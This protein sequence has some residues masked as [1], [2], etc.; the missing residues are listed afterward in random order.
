MEVKEFSKVRLSDGTEGVIVDIWDDDG[1]EFEPTHHEDL[2]DD[3]PVT[4]SVPKS[5]IAEVLS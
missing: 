2:Q 1:Y 3:A 4:Y 5:E